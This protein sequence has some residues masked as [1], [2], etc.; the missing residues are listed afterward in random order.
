MSDSRAGLPSQQRFFLVLV[1]QQILDARAQIG[2]QGL[3]HG[4]GLD[5]GAQIIDDPAAAVQQGP[6]LADQGLVLGQNLFRP[7]YPLW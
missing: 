7:V 4:S 5:T 1:V 6:H 2:L 3:G